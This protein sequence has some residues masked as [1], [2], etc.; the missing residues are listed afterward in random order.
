[1]NNTLV[2][3]YTLEADCVTDADGFIGSCLERSIPI[4][5]VI[6]QFKSDKN[7]V[8]MQFETTLTKEAVIE[9]LKKQPNSKRM[10]NSLKGN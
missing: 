10:L 3:T 9:I 1:M 8:T 6:F 5:V 4:S 2:N 7:D